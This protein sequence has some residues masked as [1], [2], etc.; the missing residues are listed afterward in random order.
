MRADLAAATAR[1]GEITG[2]IGSRDEAIAILG[3][4]EGLYEGLALPDSS[5]RAYAAER[6]RCLARLAKLETDSGRNEQAAAHYRR[7]I[8]LLEPVAAGRDG[9]TR[10]RADLAFAHHYLARTAR[11]RPGRLE[12]GERHLRRAIEFATPWRPSTPTTRRTAPS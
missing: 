2:E 8:A 1:V 6:G 11:A 12:E 9:A 7:A 4:A 3:R 10:A 5:G